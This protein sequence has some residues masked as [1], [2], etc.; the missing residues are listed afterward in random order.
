MEQ[1]AKVR[2]TGYER[3]MN[4]ED[5]YRNNPAALRELMAI[6]KKSMDLIPNKP[7]ANGDAEQ[8]EN[9]IG[10]VA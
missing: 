8:L 9:T 5:A 6:R 10:L 4:N 1:I 7:L 2:T 3:R